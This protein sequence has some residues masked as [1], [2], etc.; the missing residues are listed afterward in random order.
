MPNSWVHEARCFFVFGRTFWW[1]HKFKDEPSAWYGVKHRALRHREAMEFAKLV[2][3]SAS[4]SSLDGFDRLLDCELPGPPTGH[5]WDRPKAGDLMSP[6]VLV[7]IMHERDDMWWGTL[8]EREKRDYVQKMVGQVIAFNAERFIR[9]QLE[10]ILFNDP[11]CYGWGKSDFQ[12]F[13]KL[14]YR[15]SSTPYS[16]LL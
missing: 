11:Y 12:D 1:I 15:V 16:R 13:E 8:P 2:G 4:I 14:R 9:E 6:E 7:S 3:A 5:Y 10:W